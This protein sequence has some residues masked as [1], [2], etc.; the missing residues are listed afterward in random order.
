M[1]RTRTQRARLAAA[2]EHGGHANGSPGAASAAGLAPLE[3]VCPACHGEVRGDRQTLTCIACARRY[4]SDLHHGIFDFSLGTVFN[5]VADC[6]KWAN[7]ESTGRYLVQS[8]LRPLLER[9]FRA[10]PRHE[11]RILSVGCGVGMDVEVLNGL[12]YQ[13]YGIDPGNRSSVWA[14]RSGPQQRYFL[15]GAEHLPFPDASFDFVFMN[16]V[17]PHIGVDNDSYRVV[18][19]YVERRQMAVLEVARVM[20][21]GAYAMAANPNRLCPLDLFH[22][23][24]IARHKPRLHTRTEP[25][26]LSFEDHRRL[27]LDQAGLQ[28]IEALPITNYWGF[29]LS[30]KYMIGRMLQAGV[31]AYFS[32]I[33]SVPMRWARSTWLNPWL[34][35]LLRK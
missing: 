29:F 17:L 32:A 15:A 1:I 31:K 33:S 23:P 6:C 18:E 22:R 11:I 7:E 13:T 4:G 20:R 35:V 34:V 21:P 12:G 26:L 28:A 19:G 5:D 25:F 24:Q 16:C 8:Y 2:T 30:S 27:F 10:R 14:A 9:L 3:P